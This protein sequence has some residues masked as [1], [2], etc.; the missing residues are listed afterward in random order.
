MKRCIA[1]LLLISMLSLLSGCTVPD[2]LSSAAMDT[3]PPAAVPFEA[4]LGTE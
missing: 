2:T 3:L 1:C 4:P